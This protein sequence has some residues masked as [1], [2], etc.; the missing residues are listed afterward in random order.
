MA[1]SIP[2]F[3][4]FKGA[5]GERNL[6]ADLGD[7][8][9][10]RTMK[11]AVVQYQANMRA[12]SAHT[13]VRG[14]LAGHKRKPWKQKKTGRARH[15]DR[16]SPLWVGGATVFGPR[17]SRRW[18]YKL[19]RKQR[20]AALRSA[21]AGKLQ[22]GE[23]KEITGLS[24]EAPSSKAV[25]P[26]LAECAPHGT[27]LI[28]LTSRD[29]TLWKSFRNFPRTSVKTAD[30][31]NAYDLLASKWVLAQEGALDVVLERVGVKA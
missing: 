11:D 3:D 24:F 21:L 27:S 25:R 30:E 29:E 26:I 9:L 4:A 31:V 1:A 10:F 17:N 16:R 8:I 22:D 28:L 14:E 15:G 20:L 12:G 6:D 7:S 13:K 2:I 5:A 23:V 19:P 18:H